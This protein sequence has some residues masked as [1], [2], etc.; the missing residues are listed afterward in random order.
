MEGVRK[1]EPLVDDSASVSTYIPR[2]IGGRRVTRSGT[3]KQIALKAGNFVVDQPVSKHVLLHA[4]QT[5]GDEFTHMRYTACTSEP[6]EFK[7][8]YTLRQRQFRR[9][10]KVALVVTM[11]NEDDV[12]FAKSMFAIM[13]NIAYLCSDACTYGWGPDGWKNFTVVIVS[14]GRSKI[15]PKVLTLLGV[16][17]CYADGLAKSTV[18]GKNVKAHI[19]EYTTQVAIDK[20][21]YPRTDPKSPMVPTQVIFLLKEKNA[22]KINSHRWF[23]NAVCDV[24]DPEVTFLLDV[25][26]VPSKES[27]YHLYRAF[28]RT[29][30]VGGACGEIK[31][32]LGSGW[33]NLLNPLVATQNFEY[34]MSNILDKPLESVFGY[35]SV[36]PGAFSAYRYKAL[37][38]AP[39]DTYFRG[40]E[41]HGGADIFAAN[42]Y[43]AE[44]RILCF[45]LVTKQSDN[46]LLRYVKDASAET[47]VPDRLPELISQRRRWLNGSF[48]ASLHA[49]WNWTKIFR[50][51]H[52]S[53]RKAALVV[54]FAYNAINL[55]FSWFS[56]ANFYLAF[57]FLFDVAD[58]K[59]E[60]NPFGSASMVIF[61]VVRQ[62]YIFAIVCIFVSSLGNR[63]QGSKTLYHGMV[64]GFT[65]IMCLMLFLGF[66][67]V[68]VSIKVAVNDIEEQNTSLFSYFFKNAAFRDLVVSLCSTYGLYLFASLAHLDAWHILTCML[69]Y[70]LLLPTYINIF[71]IYAFTNLHDVSWGTKGDNAP[72]LGAVVVKTTADGKQVA[73]VEMPLTEDDLDDAYEIFAK[74]LTKQ[75]EEMHDKKKEAVNPVTQQEDGFRQFRTRVVLFWMVSNALLIILFTNEMIVDKWFPKKEGS[76]NPYLTFLFWSV[77]FLSFIR[78][79]A[80]MIYLKGHYQLKIAERKGGRGNG[81]ADPEMGQVGSPRSSSLPQP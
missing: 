51:G 34:K 13:R 24:L 15:N 11:Y 4:T 46:W 63:P 48:F 72:D 3:V 41:M 71:M 47:D 74:Q 59:N 60:T 42:M 49:V 52:S 25:G 5:T 28:E 14:D 17:G 69:Q 58:D 67:T 76:V 79:V 27:F 31:A 44:D 1:Y 50:S 26:T 80:S 43:L 57:H 23:F 22:K 55:G 8:N 35:I 65:F 6:G 18:N 75:R 32:E 30:N 64:V 29:P 36:L 40:E 9:H 20:E 19:F 54:E 33:K 56:L 78:F 38:G 70:L 7:D 16:M 73:E 53:G 10:T 77:A 61:Q 62:L 21:L 66:Y 39:L 37:Q 2:D 81:F 68:Y 12:L 45:E